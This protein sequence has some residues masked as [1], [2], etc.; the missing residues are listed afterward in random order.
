MAGTEVS[1]VVDRPPEVVWSWLT[2]VANVPRWDSMI[3]TAAW[4]DGDTPGEGAR[5]VGRVR[6][7]GRR[8]DTVQ[9]V[10]RWEP[11]V[12][13]VLK[14]LEGVAQVDLTWLLQPE[15]DG[16]RFTIRTDFGGAVA[17]VFGR[18]AGPVFIPIATR[19]GHANL[20]T[21]KRLLEAE[22]TG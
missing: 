12:R 15:G 5:L 14:T 19:Q 10:A 18:V 3:E 6:L 17:A 8:F 1:I 20:R 4:A 9:E 22:T 13:M 16:T 21:L 11:P 7:L 2:D